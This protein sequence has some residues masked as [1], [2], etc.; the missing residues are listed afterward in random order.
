MAEAVVERAE[1][2]ALFPNGMTAEAFADRLFLNA[3]VTPTQGERDA[4]I[5]AYGVGNTAGRG[6]ALIA[7]LEAGTVY[8]RL[9]N[10]G[11]VLIEYFGF[12]RRDP[13]DAPDGSLD[14]YNFWLGKLDAATLPGEDARR[15]RDAFERIKRA[16]MVQAFIV[17]IEYRTR[18]GP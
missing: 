16:E 1:F 17:S 4:V 2:R 11:F 18:F 6:A 10:T 9:Y 14:G 8:N 15:E 13:D 3:G 7:G 12:M 5:A